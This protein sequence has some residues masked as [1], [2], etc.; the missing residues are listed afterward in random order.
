MYTKSGGVIQGF[1]YRAAIWILVC[2]EL[3]A[4]TAADDIPQ[5]VL[6][7]APLAPAMLETQPVQ[8]QSS[9]IIAAAC[10]SGGLCVF[11][12][13]VNSGQAALDPRIRADAVTLYQQE[14][15]APSSSETGWNGNIADCSAGATTPSFRDTVLRRINYFRVMAGIPKVKELL[16]AYNQ[17]DQQ[18]ALMMAA[19]Q[20]LNH[21]PPSSWKCYTQAGRDGAGSSNL[22]MGAYGPGAI[23]LYMSDNGVS[24]LG[25]RRWILY[26]QTQSMGTGDIPGNGSGWQSLTNAL[27]VFDSH[28]WD[29]RPATR[30]A[31]VAW[32]PAAYVP[33]GVIY[34]AWSFAVG[35]ADFSHATVSVTVD[36]TPA[37]CTPAVLAQGYGENGV[38]WNM[39]GSGAQPSA[40]RVYQVAVRSVVV[41][42]QSRDYAYT[43]TVI[44]PN[45]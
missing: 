41:G 19:N 5:P 1:L 43:V 26:P 11:L 20:D 29:P 14:Y 40:D 44:D 28:T 42:G 8:A 4:L 6:G 32:P 36:G 24:S 3:V 23:S 13:L 22:A 12:P 25:H 39:P 37:A 35:G 31:F 21:T 17:Q 16:D 30:D 10:Q 27:R 33:Y 15:L 38:S 2:V 18:A 45:R 7:P 9:E 34:P